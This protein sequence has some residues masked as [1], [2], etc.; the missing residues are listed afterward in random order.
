MPLPH[1]QRWLLQCVAKKGKLAILI[2]D[3]FTN[4]LAINTSYIFCSILPKRE[5]LKAYSHSFLVLFQTAHDFLSSTNQLYR[6]I[7]IHYLIN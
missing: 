3:I 7:I 5:E 2:I 1:Q 4:N 6:N